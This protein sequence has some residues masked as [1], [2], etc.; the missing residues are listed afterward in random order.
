M[1]LQ[2]VI[3]SREMCWDNMILLLFLCKELNTFTRDDNLAFPDTRVTQSYALAAQ[4]YYIPKFFAHFF[5]WS[6]HSPVY[7]SRIIGAFVHHATGNIFSRAQYFRA[8]CRILS[9]FS[10]SLSTS[11]SLLLLL[12]FRMCQRSRHATEPRPHVV[13][14]SEACDVSCH[15]SQTLQRRAPRAP[16]SPPTYIL[17]EMSRNK[18]K[19]PT[20]SV[21]SR[22]VKTSRGMMS[23]WSYLRNFGRPSIVAI[24]SQ[25]DVYIG[26]RLPKR[27][28]SLKHLNITNYR[29]ILIWT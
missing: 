25:W 16:K 29:D 15:A 19:N 24:F 7:T 3:L 21:S 26:T 1:L 28:K 17:Q 8:H 11:L 23:P 5:V 13:M 9:R 6:I 12:L 14:L 10:H 2:T 22:R 4:V 20:W 27:H 18:N